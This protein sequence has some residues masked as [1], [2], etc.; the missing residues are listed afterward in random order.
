MGHAFGLFHHRG[1]LMHADQRRGA[2]EPLDAA[3]EHQHAGRGANRAAGDRSA[4]AVSGISAPV[5]GQFVISVLATATARPLARMSSPIAIASAT[6]PPGEWMRI[7]NRRPLSLST[8]S[9]KAGRRAGRDPALGRKPFRAIGRAC[10]VGA[11]DAH[12]AHRRLAARPGRRPQVGRRR[13]RSP[14]A[15]R[16]SASTNAGRPARDVAS[17]EAAGHRPSAQSV[18]L[19]PR[20]RLFA[21]SRR[22]PRK[23]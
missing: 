2:D 14:P 10:G 16:A 7:G 12:K 8:A 3:G 18:P 13:A 9:A 22:S 19:G 5:S 23:R 11:H 15:D 20:T 1:D 4:R 21:R 17:A 6:E